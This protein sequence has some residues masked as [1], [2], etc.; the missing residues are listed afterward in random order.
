MDYKQENEWLERW[1][2]ARYDLGLS[3]EEFWELSLEQLMALRNR[4]LQNMKMQNWFTAQICSV[5]ANANRKKGSRPF[6]AKDFMLDYPE[7]KV[8]NGQS[9]EYLLN[10]V[11]IIHNKII[12]RWPATKK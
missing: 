11:R 9:E 7:L 6:K 1:A 10:K 5:I 8:Q 2:F 3:E 4:Y 12:S